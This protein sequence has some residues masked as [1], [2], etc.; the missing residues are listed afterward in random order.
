MEGGG[1]EQGRGQ[2]SEGQTE[3]QSAMDTVKKRARDTETEESAVASAMV[4]CAGGHLIWMCSGGQAR[5]GQRRR[6]WHLSSLIVYVFGIS[7]SLPTSSC[8]A[9]SLRL[10]D[11]HASL[12]LAPDRTQPLA[13]DAC[14]AYRKGAQAK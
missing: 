8:I 4:T 1:Q 3:R 12:S 13:F 2:E 11:T 9:A 14:A 7:P 6:M 10:P 5:R